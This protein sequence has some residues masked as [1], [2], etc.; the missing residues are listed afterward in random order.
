MSF[1]SDSKSIEYEN[2]HKHTHYSN[3]STPDC[4]I[5]PVDIAKR[6]VELGHK[7]LSTVEHGFAG[8][9]FEY[10]DVAQKYGLKLIF[11][12]EFYYV[13][14]RLK[15]DRTNSHLV[16]LAKNNNGKRALTKLISESN[17]TGFYHHPRIDKNLVLSL[18]PE[19]VVVTSA[20]VGSYIGKYDEYEESFI[21]PMFKHFGDN[22]YLEI[23]AHT[24]PKQREYNK[25]ILDLHNRYGIPLL[26]ANDTHYIYPEQHKDRD[27]LLHSKKIF[28]PDEDGFIMDYPDSETILDRYREQGVFTDEQVLSALKNTLIVREFEDIKMSK[29]IKIPTLFPDLTHKERMNKLKDII[30]KEWRED[31]KELAKESMKKHIEAIREETDIVEKTKTEDYFLLNY[32]VIKRAIE[33]GG[34]LTRTGRGSAPSFYI[35]KLLGFTEI[36]RLEA[37]I[38]LYPTRF[39]S[40]SRIL[41]T[42]S[43][44][45]IDFNTSDPKPFIDATREIL[46]K[47]NCYYMVAYGTMQ[48]AAAFKA[49]CRARG[50][51][52]DT[53]NQ[54][55]KN[56][57]QYR[58]DPKWKDL[59]E[60]SKKF[61][62]V[63]D[64]VSPHPCANLLL[65]KPISEEIGVIRTGDKKK[66]VVYC[67]L[68]DSD[69]ADDWKYLKNDYLTVT[70]WE[71]ISDVFK[72]I[73]KP[74]LN[75]RELISETKND[76]K[77][78]D[79]YEKGLTATLNQTGT[80]SGR[81]QVM[82]Y[83]PKNIRELSG[84]VAAIRPQFQSMKGYFL[85]REPFSYNIPEFDEILKESDNFVLY[86]ENIMSTLIF[87]GFPE[88]VT[89]G[90]LKMI[91]GKDEKKINEI[92]DVFIKGFTDK[93]NS[94]ETAEQVWHIILDSAGYGFNSS[95]AYAVAL[96]SLY[97]AY[98]KANYP[99]EYFTVVFNIYEG[100]DEMTS[101]LHK[102]L[103]EFGIKIKPIRYGKSKDV[104]VENKKEN[105]IY[106]GLAS[107]KHLNHKASNELYELA[108]KN[109][110]KTFTELLVDI[111]EKTSVTTRQLEILI[112]LNFFE[113]FGEIERLLAIYN[114]FKDGKNKYKKTYVDS[115][116]EKRI[117]E[118][119]EY[120][121]T[122]D[123]TVSFP[124][125]ERIV[126]EK[127][128]LGYAETTMDVPN[129][130]CIVMDTFTRFT[131]VVTLYQLA[132]GKEIKVKIKKK[133][134]F[135][136]G[137][138][139][140][141]PG[142]YIEIL[143]TFKDFKWYRDSDGKFK[144]DYNVTELF[145]NNLRHVLQ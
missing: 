17:L 124:L 121:Q 116:K 14:D 130:H 141:E 53:A 99:L 117:S 145:I 6:A 3:I 143:Q 61:I 136:E 37:P 54:I 16:I 97:G 125:S 119:I 100:K 45:D 74:I 4:I 109:T 72:K 132:T 84:W 57:D 92:K 95:H 138:D 39:M 11:G 134:F 9:V 89:Y 34:V 36:D 142:D 75:I 66:G 120:E 127:D 123:D 110:Y 115:T 128:Y 83:K 102:E 25:I 40:V 12:V 38:T 137:R 135:S 35:N 98:L 81:P 51:S 68:I 70:V 13:E 26:H 18:N 77:I 1:V 42:Q 50:I 90:V 122:T 20:C 107:I 78:W 69:T 94:R 86:Q 112:K 62:N 5:K 131:P 23:Q 87:A 114:E 63:I 15:K 67:A 85:N 88:D 59:I 27:D 7:T 71:I 24:H 30:T 44:P 2:Y 56:L 60:E 111:T 118:L 46:G 55:S 41:E 80:S 91:S 49:L 65:D 103:K 129:S 64:S 93:T 104:Y 108:K 139:L 21:K 58:D 82:Q 52:P 79:L 48:D 96:D 10:Y 113:Q 140:V 31:K 101:L 32:Y 126:F 8:N 29:E 43:L 22:F 133:Y 73:G 47:D 106:K 105:A 28:Y 33:K 19:D 76:K 144:Q